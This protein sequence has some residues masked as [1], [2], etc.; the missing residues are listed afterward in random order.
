V[1]TAEDTYVDTS[2]LLKLYLHEPES[3]AMAA[4]RSKRRGPLAVT[5]FARLEIVNGIG[6]A[7]ARGFVSASIHRAALV[8]LDDDF[9]EGRLVLTDVS[10]RAALRLAEELSR[11]RTPVLACRTLDVLHVASALVLGS[12]RFLT[13][14]ARQ[15]KLAERA[16]LKPVV[17]R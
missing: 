3:R 6:L 17:L 5:L 10:W 16:A 8:A 1:A 15:R 13:F 2:A 4:W 11:K 9:D 12:R 7:L 14:D